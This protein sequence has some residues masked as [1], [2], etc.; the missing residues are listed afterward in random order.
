M[1]L[2]YLSLSHLSL[3]HDDHQTII[4]A[5]MF[6]TQMMTKLKWLDKVEIINY[7]IL[8]AMNIYRYYMYITHIFNRV[9]SL[10]STK[11]KLS[12]YMTLRNTLIIG[13]NSPLD[14]I[15]SN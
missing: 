2:N 9:K 3:S 5:E 12:I 8:R 7:L 1:Y 4:I 11:Y 15:S 14:L 13:Y 6:G 10:K